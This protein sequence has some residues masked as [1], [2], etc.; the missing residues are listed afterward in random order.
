VSV[1]PSLHSSTSAFS[2]PTASDHTEA[3]AAC[4]KITPYRPV[5]RAIRIHW[6]WLYG[7]RHAYF[8][9]WHSQIQYRPRSAQASCNP[10]RL[11]LPIQ[12]SYAAC[13]DKTFYIT[14]TLSS[15]DMMSSSSYWWQPTS[16]EFTT[17]FGIIVDRILLDT[18]IVLDIAVQ[19]CF[20]ACNF[21]HFCAFLCH[22]AGKYN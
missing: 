12:S 19:L 17:R 22:L 7:S 9:H 20:M 16:V 8:T 18:A 2:F 21:G 3:P 1:R 4:R 13:C 6:R 5:T 14:T 15:A 11:R 10:A